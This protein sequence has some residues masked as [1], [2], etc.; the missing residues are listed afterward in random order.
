MDTSLKIVVSD[1][2]LRNID[3][4]IDLSTVHEKIDTRRRSEMTEWFSG[5]RNLFMFK[6][7]NENLMS[8]N[9]NATHNKF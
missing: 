5:M 2:R 9:N 6:G 7:C 4:Y 8:I 1:W 3:Y